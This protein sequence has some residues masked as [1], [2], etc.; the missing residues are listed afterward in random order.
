MKIKTREEKFKIP[1]LIISV[2]FVGLMTAYILCLAS[3][4]DITSIGPIIIM[5]CAGVLLFT[6]GI[7]IK[8]QGDVVDLD[9]ESVI[10]WKLCVVFGLI[11]FLAGIFCFIVR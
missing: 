5:L 2:S 11:L 6:L 1:R 4:F 9:N 3:G 8:K 7:V 10:V